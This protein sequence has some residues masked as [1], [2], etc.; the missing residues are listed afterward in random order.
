MFSWTTAHTFMNFFYYYFFILYIFFID[1]IYTDVSFPLRRV[2]LKTYETEQHETRNNNGRI[3][4][5]I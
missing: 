5:H 1:I 4:M 3:P 2:I